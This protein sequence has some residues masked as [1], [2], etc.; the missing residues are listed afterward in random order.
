[1]QKNNLSKR[2]KIIYVALFIFLNTLNC[3]LLT[4]NFV[5][6]D[7]SP[8]PRNIFMVTNS[9]FGDFGLMVVFLSLA[10]ILNKND[11]NRMR[12]LM[13]ISLGLSFL[14]FAFSIYFGYYGMMFSFYNLAAFSSAGGGDAVGFLFASLLTLLTYS[15]PFFWLSSLILVLMFCIGVRKHR[16]NPEIRQYSFLKKTDRFSIGLS[17]LVVGILIMSSSL[18]AYQMEIDDTWYEDNNT[19]LYGTQTIGFLNYYLYDAYSYLFTDKEGYSEEKKTEVL[20]QINAFREVEQIS[21]IDGELVGNSPYEGVFAG[22]NLLLIQMESMNNFVIGL[23]VEIDG[24]WVEVTPNLNKMLASSVYFNNYYTTVGIGNTSDSDFTNMTGLYP[25]GPIYTV[26]EYANVLYPTLPRMFKAEGYRAI[27]SHANTGIFYERSTLFPELFGFDKHYAEEDFTITEDQLIHTWL[28]D[29]DFLKNTIDI[30]ASDAVNQA[31][32]AYALTIS[33]HIPYRQPEES[34]AR[35]SWFVGKPNLFPSNFHLIANETLNAQFIGYLEHCSYADYA[36]G[37]A[38]AYLHEKGLADSTIVALYGDHGCGFNIYEMFYENGALFQNEINEIITDSDLPTQIL[39]ER[40]MLS[41]IPFFIYNPNYE[42]ESALLPA[43][44]INLV[45]GT[46]S[47]V[48]T[49]ASL[50]GLSTEYYFGVDAL[51]SQKTFTYNPR[52]HDI[53][54][55]GMTISGTSQEYIINDDAYQDFYTEQKRQEILRV[56]QSHKDLNDKILKYEIFPPRE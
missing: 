20:E 51:S 43:Q 10:L 16:K 56:F 36:I 41:N 7:L 49:L 30:M 19:P 38:M 54:V 52:N 8:Y 24:Q 2:F 14:F 15:K 11:Y 33:S 5:F 1:M 21:P 45:R 32:F 12:C 6:R 55:D 29:A 42:A 9:F 27:S 53:F 26:Y 4:T 23:K 34:K 13:I 17:L 3:Y 37:Q 28:N 18:S 50:F 46:N 25:V 44:T 40:R 39:L 22:K 48:R 31:V 47:T 35:D